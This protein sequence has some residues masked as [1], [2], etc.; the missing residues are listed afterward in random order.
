MDD[1]IWMTAREAALHFGVSN[2]TIYRWIAEGRLTVTGLDHR[3][4]KLFRHLDIAR[5]ELSTRTKAKRVL[6]PA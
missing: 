4:Q 5:A 2:K 6:V 3:G 1:E